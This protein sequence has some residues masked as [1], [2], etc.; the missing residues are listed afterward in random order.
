MKRPYFLAICFILFL[1]VSCKEEQAVNL[2][3]EKFPK[4]EVIKPVEFKTEASI[5]APV[6]LCISGSSLIVPQRQTDSII[7]VF[8]LPLETEKY[9][10]YGK[11]GNG[12][13]DLNES[14]YFRQIIPEE[15]GF[16]LL[17]LN[18]HTLNYFKISDNEIVREPE[19]DK[20]L[21]ESEILNNFIS[22]GNQS[23]A[24]S[25]PFG[26]EHEFYI[27]KEG[28]KDP[29]KVGTMPLWHKFSADPM[30]LPFIYLK[31]CVAKPDGD[32][33]VSFYCYFKR[34]RI[35]SKEGD[36]IREVTVENGEKE[37]LDKN[38]SNWKFYYSHM[39][40]ATDDYIFMLADSESVEGTKDLQVFNWDGEPIAKYNLA[41]NVQSIAYDSQRKK[42]YGC[43]DEHENTIFIYALDKL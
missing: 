41:K 32:R 37:E 42:L 39:P 43:S 10:T 26:D 40:V 15:Q 2:V 3:F 12:P 22:L 8:S 7:T 24:Y 25:A 21:D 11:M 6:S 27:H 29:L 14:M 9:Y 18:N 34:F 31:S 5:L 30:E 28:Q 20:V 1:L 19:N 35:Y 16:C 13:T 17:S 4:E 36:L 33:F 38:S 23:F